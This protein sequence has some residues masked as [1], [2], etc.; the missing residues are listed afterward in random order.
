LIVERWPVL[1]Q[2]A[3]QVPAAHSIDDESALRGRRGHLHAPLQ[4][5][6]EH[7]RDR[8]K[9]GELPRCCAEISPRF[10]SRNFRPPPTANGLR[11]DAPRKIKRN[12]HQRRDDRIEWPD[13]RSLSCVPTEPR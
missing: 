13:R 11:V 7:R 4:T 1:L 5:H 9:L 10:S 12:L 2:V 3:Q 8:K 6:A